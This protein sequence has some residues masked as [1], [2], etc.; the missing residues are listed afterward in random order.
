[1]A[2]DPKNGRYVFDDQPERLK[3]KEWYD[4]LRKPV[5]KA[6]APDAPTATEDKKADCLKQRA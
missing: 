1:M 3:L 5:E 6:T 2:L 4:R